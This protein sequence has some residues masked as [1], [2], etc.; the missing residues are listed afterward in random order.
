MAERVSL[1]PTRHQ[2]SQSVTGETNHLNIRRFRAPWALT[3]DHGDTKLAS[4]FG[5]WS[6]RRL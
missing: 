4:V 2:P 3:D 5:G 1:V 6:T